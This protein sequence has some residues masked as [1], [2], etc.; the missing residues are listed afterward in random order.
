M[1]NIALAVCLSVA[2]SLA[3]DAGWRLLI[4]LACHAFLA[5]FS[6]GFMANGGGEGKAIGTQYSRP[7]QTYGPAKLFFVTRTPMNA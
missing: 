4:D 2:H 3:L 7:P 6:W 1:L 5:N